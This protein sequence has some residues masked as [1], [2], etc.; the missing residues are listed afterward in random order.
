MPRNAPFDAHHRRYENWFS[1]HA[2]AYYS[3][4]LAVRALLP[5]EGTGL[6]IGV[7]TGRFAAPLG[8]R[9]GVDPSAAMLEYARA[10]GIC[11]VQGVAEQLPFAT[12]S[13][14]HA[15]VVTTICFVDDACAMLREAR[16]V[17]KP[18]GCLV[19]GFIDRESALGQGYLARQAENVFYR[20][21]TFYSAKEVER[22]LNDSGFPC[23][24]WVQTLSGLLPE[25]SEIEPLHAG[26]GTGAFVAVRGMAL[27]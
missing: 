2:A 18:N 5:W 27:L 10:R 4:L 13:F 12:A 25:M 3:E 9:V 20:E 26:R 24:V 7:G 17:I 1:I 22:L 23:Q 21:A 14:D 15:L 16:R 19:V 6:E 11:V 8:V